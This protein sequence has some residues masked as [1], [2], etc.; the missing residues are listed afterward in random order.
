MQWKIVLC[1]NLTQWLRVLLTIFIFQRK[2]EAAQGRGTQHRY[3]G[4]SL[5]P[6]CVPNL[7]A[8]L[9][10]SPEAWLSFAAHHFGGLVRKNSG[11]REKISS[12][13]SWYLSGLWA[14][15]LPSKILVQLARFVQALL[16]R[17]CQE[18]KGVAPVSG[19]YRTSPYLVMWFISG[20][21]W[22]SHP[23]PC[24]ETCILIGVTYEPRISQD[25]KWAK[26]TS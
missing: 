19:R 20:L 15:S 10:S 9:P 2:S 4:P 1:P 22:R 18:R 7:Q 3:S 8:P 13:T 24:S 17:P 16:L 26:D 21:R 11:G 12:K 6:A 25:Q 14:L 5:W 23:W